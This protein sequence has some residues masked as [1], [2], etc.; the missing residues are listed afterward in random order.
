MAQTSGDESKKPVQYINTDIIRI[1][2]FK[3][4]FLNAVGGGTASFIATLFITSDV[5]RSH[6][7]G[8]T[9]FFLVACGSWIFCR[10]RYNKKLINTN[11]INKAIS[12][13]SN[14]TLV[15]IDNVDGEN[16]ATKS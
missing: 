6:R 3:S 8:F 15:E 7:Y 11:I 16:V 12:E 2:C 4:T 9:T 14:E 10:Y 5:T 13:R 1:P